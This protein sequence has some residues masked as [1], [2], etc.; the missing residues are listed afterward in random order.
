MPPGGEL[1]HRSERRPGLRPRGRI[2][3]NLPG[4]AVLAAGEDAETARTSSSGQAP[5]IT[6][7]AAR[8]P[9]WCRADLRPRML[10]NRGRC[11]RH[12][13][14]GRSTVAPGPRTRYELIFDPQTYRYIGSQRIAVRSAHGRRSLLDATTLI[15]SNPE[16]SRRSWVTRRGKS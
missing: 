10:P 9:R 7:P 11:T 1:R 2:T 4:V 6:A 14:A 12:A 15:T 16:N 13:V 5:S 3:A 8:R